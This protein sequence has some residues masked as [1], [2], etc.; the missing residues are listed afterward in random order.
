MLFVHLL[1]KEN[2]TTSIKVETHSTVLIRLHHL[3]RFICRSANMNVFYNQDG[4]RTRMPCKLT[5][6]FFPVT[7]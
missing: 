7:L 1:V 5:I 2:K 3:P 6:Y 4:L